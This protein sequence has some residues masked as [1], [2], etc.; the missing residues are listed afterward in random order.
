M[1]LSVL[2]IKAPH[3]ESQ[4]VWYVGEVSS[5]F[6]CRGDADVAASVQQAA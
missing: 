5:G 6:V 2:Y 3:P 1:T 4:K